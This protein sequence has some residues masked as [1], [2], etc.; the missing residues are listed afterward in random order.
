VFGRSRTTEK[1]RF[2]LLREHFDSRDHRER[3]WLVCLD[4]ELSLV[5]ILIQ[6]W[7]GVLEK[8]G[9]EE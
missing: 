8:C 4:I 7:F 5:F 6:K 3:Q 2:F 9:I 1:C